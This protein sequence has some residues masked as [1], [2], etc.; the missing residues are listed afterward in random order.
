METML[1]T[2]DFSDVRDSVEPGTYNVRVAGHE[3]GEWP[4]KEGKAPTKFIKWKL[5]TFNETEPKN[6]GRFIWHR[7]NINGPF[8]KALKDFYKATMGEDIGTNGFDPSMLYGKEVVVKTDWQIDYKTKE[9]TEY[10]EV[11]SVKPISH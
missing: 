3:V 9:P 10:I 8:A 4:G 1:I 7:T 6:N 2:P 5:E 11:K